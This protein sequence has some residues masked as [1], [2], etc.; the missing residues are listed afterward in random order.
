MNKISKYWQAGLAVA[1]LTLLAVNPVMAKGNTSAAKDGPS[2][3]ITF[4][5][6]NFGNDASQWANDGECDDPRF[7]GEGSAVELLDEDI[8]RDASDCLALYKSGDISLVPK[9]ADIVNE[10]DFGDN[11]SEWANDGE[12][13]DPRFAGKGVDDIL[14]DEDLGKDANDCRK[15]FLS[16]QLEYLGDDPNM[17]NITLDGIDF[18]DNSS[19]WANDD[20]CD[21]PRFAGKGMAEVLMDADLGKDANDCLALYQAGSITLSDAGN[22]VPDAGVI[23]FGDDSSE[24]ANDGECD[25]PRF[26]GKGMADELLDIDM[27]KDATD[28]RTLFENKQIYLAS[29]KPGDAGK[30]PDAGII[31]FGDDSSEWN[32]DGECDDPRFFGEGSGVKLLLEDLGAD[33]TDC[34]TLFEEGKISLISATNFDFGDDSSRWNNDGECDDPRFQ[35]EGMAVKVEPRDFASDATDCSALFDDGKISFVGGIGIMVPLETTPDASASGID[36]GDDSSEWA[37]DG[38]CD[39]PRFVGEGMAEELVSDDLKRDATDCR[40]LF[41]AGKI[42]LK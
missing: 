37:K 7:K 34:K 5:G 14:L 19:E 4:D 9:P 2:Q 1:A 32:N 25:D 38:E 41:E 10:I 17:N 8:A 6:I 24:W 12:C 42:S 23:D 18:G 33:A 35:G 39:D 28:C 20:E 26:A 3:T 36:F 30:A 15:L 13:D 27:G 40:A 29:G 22:K 11:S 16:G 21:D 31:D